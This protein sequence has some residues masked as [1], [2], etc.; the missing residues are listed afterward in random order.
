[1]NGDNKNLILILEDDKRLSHINSHALKSE[2]YEVRTA[3]R[4]AEARS[5]L[6]TI[7]PDVLL[8]E[9]IL[10]DGSGF[11]LCR[12]I[13]PHTAA[14]IIFL[15]SVSEA[16]CEMEGLDVGGNDYLR[17]PYGIEMLKRRVKNA[18]LH[19]ELSARSQNTTQIIT[20]GSLSIDNIARR[21][22]IDG[23]DLGLQPME[24]GV[25][26]FL[27][28]NEGKTMGAD[29]IYEKVWGQPLN[30]NKSALE[31]SV[32]RLRKRI[33]GSGYAI[34]MKRGQGYCFA[35]EKAIDDWL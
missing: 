4:I 8:L 23:A 31:K 11:D 3:F 17:K 16:S 28:H 1:M 18:L 27:I 22:Y 6:E 33:E 2:G 9:V 20:K 29:F 5:L 12:E 21:A 24:Y 15:T 34:Q 26:Y 32:S 13:R 7:S 14:F 25:L 30:D 10:P 19:I 35:A